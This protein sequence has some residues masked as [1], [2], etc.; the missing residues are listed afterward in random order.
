[1]EPENILPPIRCSCGKFLAR[2]YRQYL[3]LMHQGKT[4][5]QALN[6]LGIDK[7][8]CRIEMFNPVILSLGGFVIPESLSTDYMIELP[9]SRDIPKM[10]SLPPLVK[11]EVIERVP[12]TLPKASIPS[13]PYKKISIPLGKILPKK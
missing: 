11:T 2:K 10:P 8:C 13:A 4:P 5:E 9:R 7:V 6:E 3:A 1:M 12:T